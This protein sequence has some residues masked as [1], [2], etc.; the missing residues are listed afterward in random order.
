MPIAPN[1]AGFEFEVEKDT[2]TPPGAPASVLPLVVIGHCSDTTN[3]PIAEPIPITEPSAVQTAGG[4]GPA[5]ELGAA[6]LDPNG[7]V[8]Q[9]HLIN[10]GAANAATYG[11]ITESWANAAPPVAE[12]D[13]V[14]L[15]KDDFDVDI[16]W[17]VGGFAVG[18][19]GN[20]YRTSL[21][22]GLH[23]FAELALGT[24]TSITLPNGAGK[25]NL[26]PDEAEV[27]AYLNDLV[28]EFQAHAIGTGTYHGAA[29][30]SAPYTIAAA[31]TFANA[32]STTFPALRTSAITHVGVIGTTHGAADATASAAITAITLPTTAHEL[33]DRL[34]SF[35]LAFFGTPPTVDSG[36]T[37]RTAGTVHGAQDATNLVTATAA[38]HGIIT[39]GDAISFPTNGP[40]PDATQ[41]LT[42]LQSLRT[43]TGDFGTIVLASPISP[44]Y[45][46]T[47]AAELPELWKRNKFPLVVAF[48]RRPNIGETTTAYRTA[49]EVLGGI[50]CV[51]LAM[52]SGATYHQ[53]A[54]INTADG[55]AT[56]RRPQWWYA[57]AVAR[58]EPEVDVQFVV[59]QNGVRIR[60]SRGRLLPGCLDEASGELYSVQNRTI[61]TKTDTVRDSNGGVF[62]TQDLVLYDS[63]SDWLFAFYSKVV[64]HSLRTAAP[65]ALYA[66]TAPNG[67]PSPPAAELEQEAKDSI[68]ADVDA[69]LQPEMIGKR[70]AT[71]VL[72]SLV[73]STNATL[74]YKV[75]TVPNFYPYNGVTLKA[76][77][78]TQLVRTV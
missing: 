56:P 7:R 24:A 61:G 8:R 5:V 78:S 68:I 54:L 41:I 62:I 12:A 14:V 15:P 37:Q 65:V 59:P 39:T 38:S 70:R 40:T 31:T 58:N 4:V 50:V 22:G 76:A 48:F 60:D 55:Y 69:V 26:L 33:V 17:T 51:D 20:K 35:K 45:I 25:I 34:L 30:P 52:C 18:T 43:Y 63:N 16:D 64:N 75:T 3:A 74:A 32:I 2:K 44:S 67:F 72:F 10:S 1:P 9:I 71:Q 49:L 53:S 29:D 19:A 21:D 36:H 42:A 77:V 27:I 47:I 46:A 57:M 23:Y 66:S 11:T 6:A 28:G 13:T 73:T